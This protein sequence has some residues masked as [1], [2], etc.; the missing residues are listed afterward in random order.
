VGQNNPQKCNY[1]LYAELLSG[2]SFTTPRFTNQRTWLYRIKPTVGHKPF[3][4]MQPNN[5]EINAKFIISDYSLGNK[6]VHSQPQQMRWKPFPLVEERKVNNSNNHVDF[7]QGLY[8]ICGAGSPEM[9]TGLAIHM[10]SYNSSM[11]NKAFVNADG[12]LLLVPQLGTLQLRTE[13]GSLYVKPGYIAVVPR[14][15]LFSVNQ[16]DSESGSS[17]RGYV[18]ESYSAGHYRLP[19]LGPIGSNGLAQPRDFLYPTAQYE[20]K[21]S[22]DYTV[23]QKYC[24]EFFSYVRE[25]SSVFDVVAW[26]GNYLPYMYDLDKFVPAAAVRVDHLDPS[27]FTVLTIPTTEIGVAA[28]DFVIFPPRWAVQEHT[29]RPPYYHRNVMSEYMGNIKGRYEAKPEGFLPGG[30]SLHQIMSG[31]GPDEES[32]AANSDT[33]KELTPQRLPDDSL[34]FMFETT[35]MLRVADFAVNDYSPDADYYTCWQGLK[36]NFNP[37]QQ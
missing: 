30:A 34:S 36:N 16:I 17:C 19:E 22:N 5:T 15:I 2:T 21:H 3:T 35:Y 37:N 26:H 23:I 13:F 29:F 7:L 31:H 6:S 32:F 33:S 9:K 18:L 1:N 12:D 10:Y 11:E 28:V 4:K 14:G 27:I 20:N 8:S 25:G 24:G